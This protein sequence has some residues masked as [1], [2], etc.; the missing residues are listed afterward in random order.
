MNLSFDPH[1]LADLRYWAKYDKKK[2]DKILRLIEEIQ[3]SPFTGT[4]KP[5]PLKYMLSGCWS[6][7]IDREH[8]LVYKVEGKTLV[9]LAC[10]YHY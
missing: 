3:R 5:E 8:R 1:A 7:R 6:R 2:A 9:I 10:R 4:G